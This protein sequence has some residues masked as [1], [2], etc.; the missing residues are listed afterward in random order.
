MLS[1]LHVKA[2]L[3]E[4]AY[5]M[6]EKLIQSSDYFG[7]KKSFTHIDTT[8]GYMSKK[9]WPVKK[10]IGMELGPVGLAGKLMSELHL[11][12]EHTIV[13]N[14]SDLHTNLEITLQ[15]F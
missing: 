6:K 8:H 13:K 4:H 2:S 12:H 9:M 5:G 10:R 14:D 1:R 7:V 11:L 3:L 15:K